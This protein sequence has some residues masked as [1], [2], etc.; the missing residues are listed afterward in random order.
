MTS[1]NVR[2]EILK[3]DGRGRVRVPAA[4]REALLDEFE[5]SGASGA[6][7]ARL[8]GIKYSTFAAWVLKR[9][10]ERGRS[11]KTVPGSRAGLNDAVLSAGP[12][13]LFEALLEGGNGARRPAVGSDGL[14]I[15]LP[16][17]SR[18]LVE[19][20]VQLQMAAELVALIAQN[21]RARC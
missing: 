12:V 18:I 2:A 15:E 19:S 7:F 3:Q 17:G 21:T 5:K 6:R 20:P 13:R 1:T 16:G 4:R 8:A 10:K 11:A 9:R 14:L